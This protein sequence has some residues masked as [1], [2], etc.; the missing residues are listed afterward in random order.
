MTQ[1][2]GKLCEVECFLAEEVG[3]E[4]GGT[5]NFVPVQDKKLCFLIL[6]YP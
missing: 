4:R 5:A 1:L 3:W 2:G 6:P